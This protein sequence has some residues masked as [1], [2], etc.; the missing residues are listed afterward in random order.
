VNTGARE[1]PLPGAG[2]V[3]V[4]THGGA[5]EGILAPGAA[6]LLTV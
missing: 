3:V 4:A 6:V 1:R 2:S 5:R